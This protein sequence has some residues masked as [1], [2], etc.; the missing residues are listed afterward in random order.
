MSSVKS[1]NTSEKE[2]GQEGSRLKFEFSERLSSLLGEKLWS[3]SDLS[4]RTGLRPSKIS[5]YVRA[6]VMPNA[7]SA[8][9]LAEAFGVRTEW[10]VLGH[11]PKHV[12]HA[13][14]GEIGYYRVPVLD[15]RLAA[16]SG[17][18]NANQIVHGEMIIDDELMREMGRT[19]TDGLFI[20]H[21]DGDSMEP[22]ISDGAPVLIDSRFDRFREGV[23]AFRYGE[24]LRIKR[25]R[26]AG[27]GGYEAISANPVY[28]PERIEG[29]DLEHFAIIGKALRAWNEL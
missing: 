10:L 25:L 7:E 4:E 22:E 26:L 21:C 15:V 17:A 2:D 9:V 5:E 19:N 8:V 27:V 13:D 11:L 6:R 29:P 14:Q 18:W 3:Q 12:H 23:Y 16:G 20:A 1:D 28:P 24:H